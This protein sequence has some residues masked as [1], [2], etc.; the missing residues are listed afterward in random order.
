MCLWKLFL[1]CISQS[2]GDD[3]VTCVNKNK[4]ETTALK[5]S[6]GFKNTVYEE[7]KVLTLWCC[8][9]YTI[10]LSSFRAIAGILFVFSTSPLS[11]RSL[12]LSRVV[13]HCRSVHCQYSTDAFPEKLL[14]RKFRC[15]ISLSGARHIGD[16]VACR[17]HARGNP[18]ADSRQVKEA[19]LFDRVVIKVE[20]IG[21]R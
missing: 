18:R 3:P 9:G 12:L 13:A 6:G 4:H 14:P 19:N 16:V 17:K 2:F 20:E 5:S 7:P 11:P 8:C 15:V 10:A 1:F 21:T